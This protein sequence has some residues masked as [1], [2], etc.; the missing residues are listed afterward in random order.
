MVVAPVL[1]LAWLWRA[2]GLRFETGSFLVAAMPGSLGVWWRRAWYRRTLLRCGQRLHMNWMAYIYMSES[3]VGDDVYMGPF[4]SVVCAHIG[5]DVMLGTRV[6]VARG[7]RQHS[8]DRRDIPMR[9]QGGAPRPVTIG[10]DV[11]VGTAAVIL[12]DVAP[13]TIVGAGAVVTKTF[14]PYAILAGVPAKLL[15]QRPVGAEEGGPA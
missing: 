15:R 2:G 7:G 4:S 5:D 6:A 11:W 12:A 14:E 10:R 13:G 1:A 8:F 3:T 9:Q